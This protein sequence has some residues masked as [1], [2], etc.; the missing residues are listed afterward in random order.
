MPSVVRDPSWDP[1]AFTA[2]VPRPPRGLRRARQPL[3]DVSHVTLGLRRYEHRMIDAV[4]RSAIPSLETLACV[5]PPTRSPGLGLRSLPRLLFL[6]P[7]SRAYSRPDAAWRLL[8]LLTDVRATQP[9]LSFPRRDEGR[10]LLPFLACHAA[11]L[12]SAVSTRRAAQRPFETVSVSVPPACAGL[13]DRDTSPTA[14]PS[15]DLRRRKRSDD[16]RARAPGPSEGRVTGPRRALR[17]YRGG[18]VRL[19]HADDVPLLGVQRASAVAGA[20]ARK[21]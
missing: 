16:R 6:E 12:A 7:R 17:P 20:T 4:R 1:V 15:P 5:S 8:Q 21:G 14:P 10:N 19:A 3:D 9:E 18:C 2:P 13:P 11:T